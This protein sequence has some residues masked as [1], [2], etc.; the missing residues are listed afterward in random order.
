MVTAEDTYKAARGAWY[1]CPHVPVTAGLPD[2]GEYKM[3]L[4]MF[5][6]RHA[7]P[8]VRASLT[9]SLT[10]DGSCTTFNDCISR[11]ARRCSVRQLPL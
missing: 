6:G 4:G 1:V 3:T 2:F 10:H 9:C 8:P 5:G 11:R 7:R